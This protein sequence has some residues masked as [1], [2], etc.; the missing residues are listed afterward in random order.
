MAVDVDSLQ[1]EIGATSKKAVEQ[2]EALVTAFEGLRTKLTGGVGLTTVSK[3]MKTL[4]EA[5]KALDEN[6]VNKQKMEALAGALNS[7]SAVEKATGLTSTVNALKK[8]PE[9][10]D[11]LAQADLGKFATQMN[12]VAAAIR[13]LATEMEKVSKGFSAFPIRIQKIIQSNAGLAASNTSAAKS[14]G[15]LGSG[16]T[17]VIAKVGLYVAA[18]KRITS[19]VGG[20]VTQSNN[21]VENLNLF[22]VAM[23]DAAGAALE[24][25]EAVNEAVGIDTSEWIRN[26]GVFK[27]VTSGFGV[28]EDSANLMSKNLT[29]LGYD[30]SSFFNISTED[31]MQ[32]LQ[33]GI[34]GELEPLRRLGYALDAATLQQVAYR[35]GIEQSITTMS[36]AQKAQLRYLAIMEQSENV[37]GDLARTV[38]TPANSIR[39][40]QQQVTQL[41]RSLGN[42]LIPFLQQVIPWVQA[43]V[44]LL[45]DAIQRLALLF[46][47]ELPSI[48]YSGLDGITSG[49]TDAEEALDGVG[50][51]AKELKRYLLGI[52]ELTIIQEP[53]TGGGGAS[54]DDLGADWNLELPE[55]DF[56]KG[57]SKDVGNLKERIK[58][59]LPLIT[60]VAS[61]LAA[62]TISKALVNDLGIVKGLL[63]SLMVSA[64]ITLLVDSIQDILIDGK[65]TWDRILNGAAG[66]GLA[67]AGLGLMLASKFGL[68]WQN[69]M[70]LGGIIG[71]GLSL[72][73]MAIAS[74]IKSGLNLKNSLIGTIG[75]ALAGGAVGAGI[76][77]KKGTDIFTGAAFGAT[78][79]VGLTLMV[80]GITSQL[81]EGVTAANQIISAV[82]GAIAGA[83]LGFTLGGGV[84]AVVGLALG[85]VASIAI[86][87]RIV[88]AERDEANYLA[89]V[90][91][92]K[93]E[94]IMSVTEATALVSEWYD[95]WAPDNQVILELVKTK[96]GLAQDVQ[97]AHEGLRTMF[98]TITEDGRLAQEELDQIRVAFENYISAISADTSAN[99]DIIREALIGALGRASGDGVKYYQDLMDA[100]N[101]W[102]I[103]SQGA[104]GA[105]QQDV[106][107]ALA[108]MATADTAADYA[109]A[110]DDYQEAMGKLNAYANAESTAQLQLYAE[111]I[112]RLKTAIASGELDT[113]QVA[114]AQVALQEIGEKFAQTLSDIDEAKEAV[115]LALQTEINR[116]TMLGDADSVLQ[117]GDIKAALMAD[118]DS[119]RE[120]VIEVAN[121]FGATI[122]SAMGEA[123]E[124][125]FLGPG[126]EVSAQM[127]IDNQFVPLLNAYVS[128]A[129]SVITNSAE[130]QALPQLVLDTITDGLNTAS[131]AP[132]VDSEGWF[133]SDAWEK[134][135]Q[136]TVESSTTNAMNALD[137]SSQA[138]SFMD[139]L[140]VPFGT[141]DINELAIKNGIDAFREKVEAY[142]GIHSPADIMIPVGEALMAGIEEGFSIVPELA[143]VFDTE[144][145]NMLTSVTEAST[146]VQ[147]VL[148]ETATTFNTKMD[149]A[150]RYVDEKTLLMQNAFED[151]SIKSV[152][153]IQDIINEINRIPKTITT[154]YTLNA[155][156]IGGE[157]LRNAKQIGARVPAYA[158]GGFPDHGEL[159]LARESGPE[160]VGRIGS[161][162]AVANNDQIVQ[163]MSHANEGVI[164]AIYAMAT[165]IVNAVENSG[166]DTYLDGRKVSAG[167]TSAQNRANRMYGKTLQNV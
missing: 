29:Q 84:G 137:L 134:V 48:D 90:Q 109:A 65:L 42:L 88:K 114:E 129:E 22:T 1:I 167:T 162:T 107:L 127:L 52:D 148:G 49:A 31:A 46:G 30:I 41:S 12:Q 21:Y 131:L 86:S 10:S 68:S 18:F 72:V 50:S 100:H 136:S 34:S 141:A 99:N 140:I 85:L 133:D 39:I 160:F 166:G 123:V 119:Q 67:G 156:T 7:L 113:T 73:I 74:E 59:L 80:M 35:N 54:L 165:R 81:T 26:Q 70:L 58:E 89:A 82:G 128:G 98:D 23:G 60:G 132:P 101:E 161:Q 126:G 78:V 145:S 106:D 20:W 79:G 116:A 110:L 4:A 139:A 61:G 115:E 159:F 153:A 37:M 83:G 154:S 93:D 38:Q 36:Q 102:I 63:G 150:K 9:I 104:M 138:Q 47:F 5:S 112:E 71:V 6:P 130:I 111:E 33:S 40:L 87:A 135:I 3:Q 122:A 164:S 32:K 77:I 91:A 75:G 118:F 44:E 96:E 146:E 142:A 43:F 64:G 27:Q 55:Y 151:M 28:V 53:S 25:A 17:A 66:G 105:L 62:W 45:T 51:A 92:I 94:A 117:L 108:A 57:L 121:G 163:S 124:T 8:L 152:T 15:G 14:F 155:Q 11:S 24:Y 120:G 95:G 69:G 19:T 125:A 97:T 2:I 56:L 144:I 13:P 149:E 76:A 158:S 16:M 143:G 147:R 103:T 157:T